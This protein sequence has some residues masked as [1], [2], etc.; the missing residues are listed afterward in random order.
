VY[1]LVT[2]YGTK[3]NPEIPM[4][5]NKKHFY[6]FIAREYKA[7]SF[8][9][10]DQNDQRFKKRINYALKNWERFSKVLEHAIQ[11]FVSPPIKIL[12][13]GTY[14]GT[15]LN[16]LYQYFHNGMFDLYGVGIATTQE[17]I[18]DMEIQ[19]RATIKTVNLDP[20]NEQLRSKGHPINIPL[21]DESVDIAF[22]LDVI[23]HL[24]SPT[25]ML[26]EA[27][28]VLKTGGYLLLTTPNVT[29]IGSVFK[30]IIGK[31]NYDRLIPIDYYNEDDEW[32][33]H[34]R[35]YTMEELSIL[36]EGIGFKITEKKFF[37]GDCTKFN[38]KSF[39]QKSIDLVKMPFHLIPHFRGNI[40]VVAGKE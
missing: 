7:L 1:P 12:D 39:Q 34:F 30:L 8:E 35:E 17:F 27:Y 40:L 28:R 15:F 4:L 37:I 32:R 18:E 13:I 10:F 24:T 3:L 38:R 22:S 16:I 6:R 33:P 5:L 26:L 20:K 31:S 2:R 25:H 21:D 23:E 29:R 36:L 11:Y 14:P 9:E 19:C